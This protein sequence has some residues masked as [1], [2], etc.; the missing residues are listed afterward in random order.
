MH[1]IQDAKNDPQLLLSVRHLTIK[2]NQ[3]NL[4]ENLNFDLH[5]G[6]TVAIVGESGSGKSI[7]SLAILGLLPDNLKTT[8]QAL[9]HEQDLLHMDDPTLRSIRG[10]KIAMIFQEPMTALNPLHRVEKIIGEPLLLQ[11]ISK[12]R[13][14]K[15]VYDLLCDVGIS[16]P[17]D[18]LDRYPHE[19]SGGQ[20]QRV[21]IAAALALEPEIIIADEPTGALDSET[22]DQVLQIFSEIAASGKLVLLVTHSERVAARSSRIVTIADGS[23]ISDQ[24]Y[25]E[26]QVYHSKE[27][28]SR[29]S[30]TSRPKNRNLSFF[31][32][33]K[34]AFLNM[35]EKFSRSVLI[36]LGGS[37][38]IMSI[39]LMLSLGSGVNAYLTNLMQ[40]Q[41]NPV[42]SEV[43]MPEPEEQETS[44]SST[45][46]ITGDPTGMPMD[47]AQNSPVM[48]ND[49]VPFEQSDLEILENIDGVASLEKG[50]STFSLGNNSIMYNDRY[51]SIMNFITMSSMITTA[52]LSEGEFPQEG[53]IL[54]TQGIADSIGEDSIG[55]EVTVTLM[56]DGVITETD[57]VISGIFASSD[58]VGPT[59]VFDSI[60]MNYADVEAIA[61]ANDIEL[62]PNVVYLVAEDAQANTRVKEEIKTLG[63]QGSAME[64]I[65][66]LFTDMIDIFTYILAGVAGLSLFVSAIMILTVL[67]ISVV[68]RTQE[69]GV[70]KATGGRKKD[71]RRIFVSESFLIGVFSGSFGVGF[72]YILSIIGN[73]VVEQQF[74]TTIFLVEY[75]FIVMGM[76]ISIL[77]SVIAGLLPSVRASR[78]DPVEALRHE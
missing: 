44:N 13:V 63:Y 41:V 22:A 7:S 53:E 38:G 34:L 32:A 73:R 23:I 78:L 42:V 50:Y 40:E 76:V 74:G 71:I 62:Q 45:S 59:A 33:M 25:P 49:N 10:K 70:I 75:Q 36:A 39:I 16:E 15:R 69:I 30:L 17:E 19:L 35:K 28:L 20:R 1:S 3:Q 77:L 58:A 55:K 31:A 37:I 5:A 14:R 54:I 6:K 65:A 12:E 61:Q 72:A 26:N 2:N 29:F 11:G 51:R 60:Y 43:R 9:Y 4:V 56:M 21:M 64:S 47:P 68:E 67:Y 46:E 27:H 66:K 8:G 57:M 48:R 52:N 18:K 24:E